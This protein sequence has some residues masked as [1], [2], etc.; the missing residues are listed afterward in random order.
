MIDLSIIFGT[1]NRLAHL[2]GCIESAR[3]SA[4]GVHYEFVI[5]DGGSTDGSLEYLRAQPGVV[6]IEHGEL[7]G[8]VAAYNDC[9]YRARGRYVAHLNDDLTV[10]GSLL[11]DSVKAMDEQPDIGQLVFRYGAAKYHTRGKYLYAAFGMTRH[12]LGEQAGW[13]NGYH[14]FCGDLHLSMSI[15]QQGFRVE[16]APGE[17]T[18]HAAPN[19]LRG[20]GQGWHSD[21]HVKRDWALY[22]EHWRHIDG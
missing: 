17:V 8:P 11:A 2:K 4:V 13:F 19:A 7:R 1:Y 5:C 10:N 12:E 6:L 14:Y 18:H 15:H 3:R 22:D 21:I 20:G 16:F 9:F